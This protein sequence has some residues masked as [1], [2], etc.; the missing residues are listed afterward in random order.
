MQG[1]CVTPPLAKVT[2]QWLSYLKKRRM[3]SCSLL[4]LLLSQCSCKGSQRPYTGFDL[5]PLRSKDDAFERAIYVDSKSTEQ[6]CYFFDVSTRHKAKARK[7]C[8]KAFKIA[9]EKK[10]RQVAHNECL[11]ARIKDTEA[12]LEDISGI[13]PIGTK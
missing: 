13:Q 6:L 9:N 7:D 8:E 2:D 11:S 3:Q 10:M 12:L 4:N 5:S 1:N